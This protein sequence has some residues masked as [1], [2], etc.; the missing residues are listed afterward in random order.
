MKICR[1]CNKPGDFYKGNAT[2]KICKRNYQVNYRKLHREACNAANKSWYARNKEHQNA[3]SYMQKR[4]IRQATPK[5]LSK[6]NR[7]TIR[8]FYLNKP[9]DHHVD[10]IVPIKGEN[11]C[12]L[13]VPWN[14]RYLFWRDNLIKSNKV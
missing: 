11:V 13:H 10:H 1:I 9:K 3:N 8:Q 2:C 14:L 4:R 7:R 6:E 5:C 12:G